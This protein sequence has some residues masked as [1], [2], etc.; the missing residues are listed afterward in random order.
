[1]KNSFQQPAGALRV[2]GNALWADK[3]NAIAAFQALVNDVLQDM[4]EHIIDTH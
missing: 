4:P 2:S 1:M 3:C